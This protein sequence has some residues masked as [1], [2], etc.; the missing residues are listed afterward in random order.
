MPSDPKVMSFLDHLEELRRRLIKSIASILIFSIAIYFFSEQIIDY[1]SRPVG[2]VYFTAPTEAFAVRIKLSLILGLIASIPVI[3]YQLWQFIVPG[4][5]KREVG[6]VIPVVSV[7]TLFFF[8]GVVF[9]YFLVLPLGIKFLL[10]YQTEKLLPLIKIGDYISFVSWMVL[11]FGLVFQLP[12]ITFF[13]GKLGIV[14]S[15]S[16]AKGRKYAFVSIL[17]LAA[18]LTPSPDV[19]SQLLLGIPLYI[20]Y[21]ISIIVVRI[22]AR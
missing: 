19:F 2:T 6:Y 4:L 11:A 9:C 16:L 5:S 13:L 3:L 20:L 22:T 18:V 14:S 17:I 10:G 7:S 1:L 15:Y 8:G 12:I 21:E